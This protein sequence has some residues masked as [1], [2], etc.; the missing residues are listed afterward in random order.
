M[1]KGRGRDPRVLTSPP[2][3]QL[4]ARVPAQTQ[5]VRPQPQM[6][7]S[8]K[9][10][11]RTPTLSRAPI[12]KPEPDYEVVEFPS[13]QYVNAKLQPPPPPPPR[14]P[15]GHPVEAASCGLCGGGGARVRCTECGRRALCASCDDMYHRHPK[16]RHHQRQALSLNQMRDE[17]P[18]LPPKAAPPVPP[19]R[20]HKISGDRM[21]ASPRPP[22]VAEQRNSTLGSH[23]INPMM[24]TQTMPLNNRPS[25]HNQQ[26]P[27]HLQKLAAGPTHL[28]SVPYLPAAHHSPAPVVPAQTNTLGHLT[29]WGRP[30]GSL[31]GFNV[32]PNM[33]QQ[34]MG[35]ESW[36]SPESVQAQNWGRP[37]RRGASVLELSGGGMGGMGGMV[38]A[39]CPG[40]AGCA[41]GWRYGSCASLDH[42]PWAAWPPACC[43]P[44]APL[45]HPHAHA[46]P[47][48]H[49]PQTPQPY[50]RVDSR[51]VS[52]AASRAGSRAASPAMS[53]RSRASRRPKHRTP[54]PP[55]LPSSDADSESESDSDRGHDNSRS[56]AHDNSRG[57][58]HETSR[59]RVHRRDSDRARSRGPESERG[60]GNVPDSERGRGNEPERE[61]RLSHVANEAP[62]KQEETEEWLGP[63]PAPAAAAWQCE[64]CTFVNEPGERVCAVC[65]RTPTAAPQIVQAPG[66]ATSGR[67]A[68]SPR[69]AAENARSV[70]DSARSVAESARGISRL[71]LD[72]DPPPPRTVNRVA[73]PSPVRVVDSRTHQ[74]GESTSNKTVPKKER[75]STGCGPSPPREENNRKQI[76]R[77]V[78]PTREQSVEPSRRHDM[79][80]GPSPPRETQHSISVG[81]SPPRQNISMRVS[82]YKEV[83]Q[84]EPPV[85]HSISVGPSPPRENTIRA[86]PVQKKSAGTSPPR[87]AIESRSSS[88]SLRA[89]VSNTGTSPP[90]QSISTQ[91]YEVP[92]AWERAPSASRS[93]ARRR[94]R[95]DSRRERSHSR[96]SLSSDTRESER[97]AR[98]SGGGGGRW[99]WRET[100]DSSP[101]EWSG[102]ER[103]PPAR[104]TRRASH[105]DLRREPRAPRRASYYSQVPRSPRVERQRAPA[106][107][108]PHAPRLAPRPAPRAP[109]P[110]P[111][112]LLLAG[113]P[114]PPRGAAASAGR[115]R[116]S[117]A[118]P[119]TSTC[120]AS[121]APRAAPATTRRYPAAPAWS[122]SER[123][124]PARLTRRASHLDLRREP[125]APRRASYYSQVPRSPRVERQRAPAARAPHA[126][127]LAPRPA[128]RAPRPAPRQ[129]LLAGTPQPPRGAAA[130]AGRPRASRAAPRTSTCAASPAPR[131]APATTRRYP[132]APAW[133]GSE[134][135]PP[136]RLTRRASHLDLRRE[137]RAPRRAS[138]YSQVPRSPRVERQRAPAARA[139][140]APR[141]APRPAPRAPRPAPR[142]LLL[143][144]TPQP[145]RGA[146]ASAGRPRASRA[147]PRTSTCAASPAPRAAPATT[148][149]YPAAPAWSGSERRPPARL[150]RRASHLDLRR[151][152]RAPRRASYYS[153]VPRSPRVERQRAPAA[154]APHAPRLAPRPAPRAPRPAPR[155]LLLAGTPQPPR[156]AAASAGRP[157]ASRAAPRTSTCAAS[158]A[159]RAAPAT[160]RRYPAAPAWSG[161]E[162]RPPARL[163]RR[164]SHLDLRR[165]PR[166][167][168][169]ASYYSQVPRSPRVERQR[170]PAA[171]APHAPRLA[172]RPAPR[173]PRPAPRQLLLAGTPQPPRGAA[174]SAGRP[175]ASRAAPRTSTCAASPAPRA[176]PATTRRYPAAPAW[177]G[178]ERRPPARLTRRAPR[179]STCAASPAPRAAP[180]TTRRYPAAPAWSGS[181]RRPPARLTRRASHLDLRRE[182]RAPRRAS[183]YS[184]V[185][186]SPRVERQRAP[187]A[188]APHAPR[189][190]HLDLRREPRA[191]RRA[192]YY[193]QVPR[194]PRVERQRAP[195]A[196]AP[197]APCRAPRQLLLAGLSYH[198]PPQPPL[199]RESPNSPRVEISKRPCRFY[200]A[201]PEPGRAM[202]MEAL[203]GAGAAGAASRGLELARLMAEAERLGFSAAEVQAAL[204]QSPAAP[205]AW[206]RGRWPSL[207]AGVRAA[208][209]RLAPNARVSELEARAALAR[210][211]GAMWPAVTDCVERHRRQTE[212]GTSS[213]RRLRGRVWGSPAGADDDA[214]PPPR[215]HTRAEDSSDEYEPPPNKLRD[216][217]WMYL[218]LDAAREPVEPWAVVPHP[219]DDV[220]DDVAADLKRLLVGASAPV[221]PD[222]LVLGGFLPDELAAMSA[223]DGNVGGKP[224]LLDF[225]QSENDFIEAYNALTRSSPLPNVNN[226]KDGSDGA[227][228]SAETDS[229]RDTFDVDENDLYSNIEKNTNINNNIN[230]QTNHTSHELID[231]NK[232]KKRSP[233]KDKSNESLEVTLNNVYTMQQTS[234]LS[235]SPTKPNIAADEDRITN[236]TL[237]SSQQFDTPNKD[238]TSNVE[239]ENASI[240]TANAEPILSDVPI[241]SPIPKTVTE[242]NN[243]KNTSPTPQ[244]AVQKNIRKVTTENNIEKTQADIQ[245]QDKSNNLNDLVDNTQRL[246]QQM[247]DEINSDINSIDSRNISQSEA[248]SSSNESDI[249]TEHESSYSDTE[250]KETDELSTNESESSDEESEEDRLHERRPTIIQRTSSEENDQFEEAMDHIEDQMEDFKNTNIEILDSIARSLQEE[251]T[252]SLTI[253]EPK[254][255][256]ERREDLNNNL[257]VEVNSFEEIYAQL[258]S[259]N[260]GK[261][262]PTRPDHNKSNDQQNSR[263]ELTS[264][265]VQPVI[266]NN[267]NDKQKSPDNASIGNQNNIISIQDEPKNVSPEPIM[268]PRINIT[269]QLVAISTFKAMPPIQLIISENNQI[270]LNAI[271]EHLEGNEEINNEI[272]EHTVVQITEETSALENDFIITETPVTSMKSLPQSSDED[273]SMGTADSDVTPTEQTDLVDDDNTI[274][275]NNTNTQENLSNKITE[276]VDRT[277]SKDVS[278]ILDN[279]V[280]INNEVS[281]SNNKSPEKIIT[282]PQNQS[283]INK[284]FNAIKSNIPK[285]VKVVQNNKQKGDK[286]S[287]KVIASKVPVRRGSLKQYPAPAPPKSH[288]GNIQ[289]GH[290]KQ[291]QTRLFDN[292][293]PKTSISVPS[294]VEAKPSTSTMHKKKPAPPPPTQ[295]AKQP[296]PSK[297]APPKEK[298]SNFFRESCRTEDE[299]T[300]SD[301]EDTPVPF[302]K[303]SEEP[304]RPPSPPPPVTVRRVS[305]Q[306]IDLAKVRIPEGSPERQ[307]RMLLAEGASET[308]EQARLA[309]EL[310]SRGAEAAAALL[311]ALECADLPAAL[312]YLHQDCE[313]CAER[314]PEHEMVSMLRC[315]HRC[316]RSCARLYFTVQVTE[317]SIADC[318]CPYCKLPELESLPEDEWLEYFAH[319]DIQL[320]T[321]LEA[322]VH[323][324]FQRK[325]RDRTLARDPNFRWCMECSSGFFVHPKQK[326]IRCPECRSVS[327]AKCRKQWSVNHEG[328][329]CEQYTAWLEDNDPERAI[330][331][332]QQHLRENGLECPRC[333]FKYSLSRG[334]CMHFTCTQCKY[335]FCYGCGKPF[336]MGARCGLSEYC[337]KLGLHAHHP[338]NCLF[339]LRDKEPHELQTLLQMNNVEYETAAPE[340]SPNR[341]PIQLQRETPTGLVDGT[342]GS[343]APAN[344]AGLC[345]NHYLEYLSRVV[346]ARGLDPLPL[347]DVGD[348]ET[349][350]RRAALRPPPR[351]YGSLDG[352]YRRALQEIVKEKIPLD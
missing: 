332:V 288:F 136:A 239:I 68:D 107:R 268:I 17:R 28:G 112:Q 245:S 143:A 349:L 337:A 260:K 201:S 72:D 164:A 263:S 265:N 345:K 325:L 210:H 223:A 213:E 343:E 102:S 234:Q 105:L 11:L 285:L 52:R 47:H 312:A 214:A 254:I 219:Y 203:A 272:Q 282:K 42:Q 25:Q 65:C 277:E 119:R 33:M 231:S 56:H 278:D 158:P 346:R 110:A 131:A 40:C 222:D 162:R 176:A 224:H 22:S 30:R 92:N 172:P 202:S 276:N 220:A 248:D 336:M 39:A 86:S 133:S 339:Y 228:F 308:W 311:A 292:K 323:E 328:L 319:L 103:R 347:L 194:S 88:T 123:R 44:P 179:T 269:K 229:K 329:T 139:P 49:A 128:P 209:A 168:R 115:P 301:A 290:V 147:A 148:R 207:C 241:T 251:H 95:D 76:N 97:S 293:F 226:R 217:D 77:L 4:A 163:T 38:G 188:R 57:H 233:E 287:P 19:P 113:T 351:P 135:R 132:A 221:I 93:R 246:I 137:P 55:P 96:H 45:A 243:V 156:G 300:E 91:T 294:T 313:L 43:H 175:R 157:R 315:T 98:T 127:R 59:S 338:R 199:E 71:D 5:G 208:A 84:P 270:A 27:P 117:R 108:A 63:A 8:S 230:M 185:P 314:L 235:S 350:V 171:R 61:R 74:N 252:I 106:A 247:R 274:L 192:S 80:V 90:P 129:L 324:L 141:L 264:N 78:T 297:A 99:E 286:T 111:R 29:G 206:L 302:S 299:W 322:D 200:A 125:R 69:T 37:M 169:R 54:S 317:R 205:L 310:V 100:R 195:A 189:A 12:A 305:G 318:V 182:P 116:A 31:P 279:K 340:G 284:T 177:S 236:I 281:D 155:Q 126:P 70:A 250:D 138:Y 82:P 21:S 216:D 326:K 120:A 307:A 15:T 348:L 58:A 249:S 154:R 303:E 215:A 81:P 146:A 262:S 149:R 178:S 273:D 186:R 79:G 34:Q 67:R 145:P 316:C 64:H 341:C 261:V 271:I 46:H 266:T 255:T 60:R 304:N 130:S 7:S 184:Q 174:A 18:P 309:V 267:K 142:Q 173:A 24:H 170:A 35:P 32:P 257:F 191:P 51:A 344:Y 320:K 335:E 190:S 75:I 122:G 253:D 114:Q 198:L 321:L 3:A 89:N 9:L 48:M 53:V 237:N 151:E 296:S 331:A 10:T 244:V 41:G 167:P 85:R 256:N 1:L 87:D 283:K 2:P 204:A 73:S 193:S 212:Q 165:E 197:H 298:K 280:E 259:N 334:G 333:H 104:L 240:S 152:P 23:S 187:A 26:I 306:I 109:R 140:H 258:N 196:R 160:T 153:Q 66:D 183:Y 50:R 20:R 211:R 121:P 330:A 352:L 227:H 62:P 118:A 161:S 36:E 289:S 83:K 94:F 327:C 238:L 134:R 225:I 295:E 181:E 150:T 101:P 16:R 291:L 232:L 166:A 159:P 144:G 242:T 342:C 13:E 275:E 6:H 218:P 180:A 124:P 14:P